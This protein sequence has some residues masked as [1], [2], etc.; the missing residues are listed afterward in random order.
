MCYRFRLC[1]F[2]RVPQ[3][4]RHTKT[5]K[6]TTQVETERSFFFLFCLQFLGERVS[7][8]GWCVEISNMFSFLFQS[9]FSHFQL[10]LKDEICL[11]LTLFLSP[12]TAVR[13]AITEEK[14]KFCTFLVF[15]SLFKNFLY[16]ASRDLF[17]VIF[18]FKDGVVFVGFSYSNSK[19]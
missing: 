14:R 9:F 8:L 11:Q 12:D 7:F 10:T 18:P 6:K 15:F 13:G 17:L 16:F 2:L 5:F 3:S 4:L 1:I 19:W